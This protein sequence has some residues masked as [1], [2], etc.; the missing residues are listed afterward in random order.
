M[1]VKKAVWYRDD[2]S[3]KEAAI[4]NMKSDKKINDYNHLRNAFQRLIIKEISSV[5]F[6]PFSD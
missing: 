5:I 1:L 3:F 4:S 6:D 2:S